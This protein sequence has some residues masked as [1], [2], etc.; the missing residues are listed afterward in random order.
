MAAQAARMKNA[1][2]EPKRREPMGLPT[3]DP[4]IAGGVVVATAL[5]DA[6]DVQFTAAFAARR[7]V[8][9]G[10]VEQ[11]LVSARGL[12]GHQLYVEFCLSA[13]RRDWVLYR[14]VPVDHGAEPGRGVPAPGKGRG[15]PRGA[16][17][18]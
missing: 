8:G 15:S 2:L 17:P 3:I 5:T 11:R 4:L 13:V 7:R 12:C 14:R 16:D 18:T 10:V 9:G 6:I 1:R